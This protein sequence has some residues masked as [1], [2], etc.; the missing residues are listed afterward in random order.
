MA[1]NSKIIGFQSGHD[2]A[3]CVLENGIP[4][5]HEELERFTREKE[6]FGDGLQMFFDIVEDVDDIKYF[7]Y[8]NPGNRT[9]RLQAGSMDTNLESSKT[10]NSLIEKNNGQFYI[11]SHHQSHA[12]NA[13]FSSNYDEALIITIDG[14]GIDKT[15]WKDITSERDGTDE[16]SFP[17]SFTFWMGK[18]NK[19]RPLKRIH[20]YEITLGSPYKIFTRDLFGLSGG[21]PHGNQAGT[22]MAMACM[23]DSDKHWK[24]FYDSL[25]RGGGGPSVYN[26]N[27]AK[28]Y[29]DLIESE[30]DEKKKE[31]LKFDVAAGIQ[32]AV[33]TI[34]REYITPYIEEYKPKNV[35]MA[36]GVALNSVIVGKMYDWYPDVE[37]IYV[38]PV[39][40]DAGLA[41]GS[42][43]YVYH[44]V[45]GNPRINW[46]DNASPYLGRTY[47]EESIW[48]EIKK[49]EEKI[50]FEVVD[51]NH[52]VD[53]LIEQNIVSVFGGGSESGRR[54]L[55]NRSILCDPRSPDMKD[56]INEKVKHRQWF[57]PFAPSITREDVKDW[58]V[59][60]VDSPYMTSVI[61]F[62]EEVR[63]KVPAVVHFDGSARLQ[64]VT[65]NDNEWY[66]GFIKKFQEKTEVPILLNTSFNDREPIVETPEHAINCYMGTNIDYLYFFE[67]G[68]LVSKK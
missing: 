58:F 2:V 46:E 38:C 43:Q 31:T 24:E 20:M 55:G 53:L 15:D 21:Y 32:R 35:C 48:D 17:T 28:K 26:M 52:I 67:Y 61:K 64:T 57:R 8:G 1:N 50:S 3:Y 22:V 13:F 56:I 66:Y 62:K 36:G 19:I 41:I 60:D 42:A 11:I 6:P 10:M 51:D 44:Q 37:N 45:M 68:I 59:R 40:Y 16:F 23:G 34:S 54:A 14:A 7:C 30:T 47:D 27:L 12:A 33:E 65:K 18:G 25:K 5:I 4:I 29:R 49:Q 63:H 39:P 9:G